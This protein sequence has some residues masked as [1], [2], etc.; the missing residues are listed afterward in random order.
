MLRILYFSTR[1]TQ[2]HSVLKNNVER[3][4]M[5]NFILGR[6]DILKDMYNVK[7]LG[8]LGEGCLIIW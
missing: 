5:I 7:S 6:G 4:G 3:G 8:G 2:V 1:N